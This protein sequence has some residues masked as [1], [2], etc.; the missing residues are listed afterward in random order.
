MMVSLIMV[1]RVGT[2]G[3]EEGRSSG[4]LKQKGFVMVI[5][6]MGYMLRRCAYIH[7]KGRFRGWIKVQLEISDNQILMI[8]KA[9]WYVCSV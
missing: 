8:L 9:S 3:F 5:L 7:R 4:E 1:K 2:C 6:V